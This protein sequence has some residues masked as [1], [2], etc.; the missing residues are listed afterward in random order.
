MRS[1][2][3]G[4]SRAGEISGGLVGNPT[5]F[6]FGDSWQFEIYLESVNTSDNTLRKPKITERHG[7]APEQYPDCEEW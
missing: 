7:E 1:F 5:L 6:D 2:Q 4:G 3:S